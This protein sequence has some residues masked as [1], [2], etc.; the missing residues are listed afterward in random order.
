MRGDVLR[1]RLARDGA[2]HRAA[3]DHQLR[4]Q[5]HLQQM[6]TMAH[7]QKRLRARCGGGFERAAGAAQARDVIV[8]RAG[9]GGSLAD[10]RGLWW[11]T[12]CGRDATARLADGGRTSAT[13]APA[14]RHP[15]TASGSGPYPP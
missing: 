6:N 2:K 1:L 5:G 3:A 13:A 11:A 8:S 14:Q 10:G 12:T 15:Q 4:H 7:E 9:C